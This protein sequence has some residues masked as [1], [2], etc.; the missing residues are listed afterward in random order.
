MEIETT[1]E[2][3]LPII[4]LLKYLGL[5]PCSIVHLPKP[6]ELTNSVSPRKHLNFQVDHSW[7]S[8]LFPVAVQTYFGMRL[9]FGYIQVLHTT[10]FNVDFNFPVVISAVSGT[11]LG[12]CAFG[13]TLVAHLKRKQ[14]AILLNQWQQTEMEIGTLILMSTAIFFSRKETTRRMSQTE[15]SQNLSSSLDLNLLYK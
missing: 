1:L 12:T 2:K 14:L 13:I 10:V 6:F 15:A 9:A 8:F 3:C 4:H 7:K 11:L 5:F